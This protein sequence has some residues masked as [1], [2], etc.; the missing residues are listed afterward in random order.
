MTPH[1]LPPPQP[2]LQ[3]P[4]DA[5]AHQIRVLVVDDH[6]AVRAALAGVL[7]DAPD[8]TPVAVAADAAD[9]LRQVRR[10]WPDVVILDYYLPGEDG[11]SL[12]AELTKLHPRPRVLLYSAFSGPAMGVAARLAGADG[13]L[14]KD[15]PADELC[16]AVRA[17]ATGEQTMPALPAPAMLMLAAHL[18]TD[19]T[20]LCA[21]LLDGAS[22]QETAM[23]LGLS[24]AWIDARRWAIL[25]RL[26]PLLHS[27]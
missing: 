19:D 23:T 17:V 7:T 11:L 18:D 1:P 2:H 25:R 9:G 27:R 13:A 5:A 3:S 12:V 10:R 15:A 26:R 21:M 22:P 6:P 24:E 20:R 4:A 8:L 14:P 16:R